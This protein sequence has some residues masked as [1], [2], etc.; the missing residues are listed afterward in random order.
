MEMKAKFEA[1]RNNL[2][3]VREKIMANNKFIG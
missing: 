2:L 3:C 1:I